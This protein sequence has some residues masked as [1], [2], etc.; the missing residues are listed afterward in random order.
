M[1]NSL[2]QVPVSLLLDPGQTA[3]TK[4]VR[5]ALRQYAN[6]G[7]AELERRT[8]LSRHTVLRGKG[9]AIAGNRASGGPRVN[10]PAALLA[11]RTVKAQAK[12]LYGLLQVTPNFGGRGGQFTYTTLCAL[13]RLGRNTLKRAVAQLVGAGWLQ[14]NQRSR[15]SPLQFTLGNPELA[16]SEAEAEVAG[17]RLK[18]VRFG[19]EAIM[20]EYLSLLIDSDEFTDNA[21]PGFLV[22]PLTSERL[23]LDRFYPP[24]VAFEFHGA[25][26]FRSTGRFTQAQV[27]AQHLRDLIK[28]G[29]C[30]YRGIQLVII[31]ADDLSLQGIARK[32]GQTMPLRDLAGH[33][34]LID[35]LEDA[36]LTYGAAANAVRQC[37]H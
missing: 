16:Q 9:R 17:R 14:T 23:E 35:L 37:S 6:A 2:I 30:L 26:H 33:E 10:V 5:I 28:A 18:R 25:Q 8:G 15:V 27:D 34:P 22:N 21:R 20:Q 1:E 31:S 32:I 36:S 13:T 7:P 29:I 19:G 11:D 3:A 24:K 4:V 12:V